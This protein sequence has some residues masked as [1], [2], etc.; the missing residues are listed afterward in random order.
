VDDDLHAE[1]AEL[2]ARLAEL[3]ARVGAH[4][5]PGARA[6]EPSQGEEP[7]TGGEPRT[8]RRG[9]LKLAGAA[10]AGL[11]GGAVAASA[12]PA[13]AANGD[14]L[15]L[16]SMANTAS[17][18]T[19]LTSPNGLEVVAGGSSGGTGVAIRG[20]GDG[21]SSGG[22]GV[23]GFSSSGTGTSGGTANGTA[24][25][26]TTFNPGGIGLKLTG[27]GGPSIRFVD[28]ASIPPASGSWKAGDL[29]GGPGGVWFCYQ[30]GTGAASKW[31][32]M[33]S[34]LVTLPTPTRVYDSRPGQPPV[35][36]GPKTPLAAA[37]PRTVDCKGNGSGVPA[38]VSAV[39][40]SIVATGTTTGT[41]G[42][43]SVY[44]AGVAWPGTS[45]LNWSGPGQTV[46][47][48][49]VSAV[50]AQARVD[51]YAGST[52]DVVVDVIGFHP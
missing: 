28:G 1:L 36:I 20:Q 7:G 42:Y 3:E 48:T 18:V 14:P 19:Q 41:G 39:L 43:L 44:K 49:T 27:T 38:G 35:A 4:G 52:T 45:N 2:R 51:L 12:A 29:V 15:I 21:G 31:V 5:A 32:K 37:T 10:A 23:A 26:G 50:D 13:A 24:L 40:L 33:S 6:G 30:G 8:D 47:V 22:F 17:S 11:V 9:A 16:G 34:A 25:A 46:A